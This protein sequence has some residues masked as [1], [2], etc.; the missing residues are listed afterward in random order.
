MNRIFIKKLYILLLLLFAPS[1][2]VSASKSI[3]DS[4]KEAISQTLTRIVQREVKGV[5]VR[6]ANISQRG[7]KVVVYTTIG[8]SY[9]P[10]REDNLEAIY[11]S[12][13][14]CLPN[15]LSSKNF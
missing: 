13:R 4:T 12:V 5:P 8:M 7:N 2:V 10:V 6:V 15:S 14:L 3:T 9:Y 11:D 1:L